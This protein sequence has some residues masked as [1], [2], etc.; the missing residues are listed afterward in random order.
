MNRETLTYTGEL[1]VET[2]WCGISHAVP[3]Q[4]RDHMNRQHHDGEKQEGIYCPLGHIWVFSGEPRVKV[5]GRQLAEAEA[6]LTATRD[7]LA[8]AEREQGRERKRAARGVCPCCK[9][10]FVNVA[11]HVHGQHPD[12]VEANG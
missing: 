8:A 9:R 6:Q 2:C 10:S 1:V 7:Q 11:R 3:R 5:L 4:L 12:Y